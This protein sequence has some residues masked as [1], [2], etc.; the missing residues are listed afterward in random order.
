MRGCTA[1]F[2][3]VFK[4]E[5]RKGWDI[6]LE[7]YASEFQGLSEPVELHIFTKPFA[8]KDQVGGV[9]AG[10]CHSQPIGPS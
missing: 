1:V 5:T 7:A 2:M 8:N 4:W 3:S 9:Q 10:G 6:L